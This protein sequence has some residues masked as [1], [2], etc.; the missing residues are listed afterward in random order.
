M[1]DGALALSGHIMEGVKGLNEH[2]KRLFANDTA[3]ELEL[4]D[5]MRQALSTASLPSRCNSVDRGR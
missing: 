5:V 3:L 4:S 2:K 1:A